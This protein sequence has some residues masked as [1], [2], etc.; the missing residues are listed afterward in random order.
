M[1]LEWKAG[2]DFVQVVDTLES[3]I[4]KRAGC[5]EEVMMEAWRFSDKTID[6]PGTE[7]AV[8]RSEAIWQFPFIDGTDP[9]RVGDR[10]IDATS[11]C[12]TVVQVDQFRGETRRR[13]FTRRISLRADVA[14]WMDLEEAIWDPIAPE[15]P[16]GPE[17]E[18]VDW[19]LIKPAL[20]AY[21]AR[22]ETALDPVA[23]EPA[24]QK[25]RITL[26][27]PIEATPN[28]RLRSHTGRSFRIVE[29][30]IKNELGEGWQYE[31]I[32]ET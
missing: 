28:Y 31:A 10:L 20:R 17:L 21:A 30:S 25:Y 12:W 14:E 1:T 3:V 29:Q 22:I 8:R 15:P 32:L 19:L 16:T 6:E 2:G 13:C 27:E 5:S 23:G 26:T 18:I 9:P 7:G 24:V 11:V 4:L